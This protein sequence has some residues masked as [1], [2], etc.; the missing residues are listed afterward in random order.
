MWIKI[1]ESLEEIPFG[2]NDLAEADAADKRI[3]LGKYKDDY[4]PL[5]P[6]ARM[7]AEGWQT[8]LLMFL[9]TWFVPSIDINFA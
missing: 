4:L 7:Q 3:C 5:L 2:P 8:V 1:A 6:N 9:E